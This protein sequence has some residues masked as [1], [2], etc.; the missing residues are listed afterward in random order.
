MKPVV[1]AAAMLAFGAA[2]ALAASPIEGNWTNPKHS[3]TVRIAPCGAQALCGRVVSAS[4]Q[5]RA[6]AADGGTARLIG[7]Q[8]MSDLVQT[9]ERSWHGTIFVPDV[10]RTAEADIRQTGPRSIEVEGCAM[11]GLLCKSQTWTRVAGPPP[12]KRR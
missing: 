11:G 8:L 5:A 4:A 9:G 6:D 2:P 1:I 10:N 7:T 12:R 3:V